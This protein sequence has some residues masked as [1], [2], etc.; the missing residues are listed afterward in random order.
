MELIVPDEN[1]Q[2]TYH[3]LLGA[4]SRGTAEHSGALRGNGRTTLRVMVT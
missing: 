3:V 4:P 2:C 1:L